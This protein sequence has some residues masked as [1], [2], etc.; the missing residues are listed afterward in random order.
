M[1]KSNVSPQQIY[2]YVLTSCVHQNIKKT[3]FPESCLKLFGFFDKWA[4]LLISLQQFI[5]ECFC[6]QLIS[7]IYNL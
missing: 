5:D 7:W 1:I 4:Y 3:L 2:V 6:A